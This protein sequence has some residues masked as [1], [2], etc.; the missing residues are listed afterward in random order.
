MSGRRSG[1]PNPAGAHFLADRGVITRLVRAAGI[2]P[3]SLVLDLGAGRGAITLALAAAGA[4]VVAIERDPRLAASLRR[5]VSG[6]SGGAGRLPV[7]VVEADLRTVPLPRREFEVVAN[8]PFSLTTALLRRLLTGPAVRLAGAELIIAWGAA[9]WLTAVPRDA[10]TAWWAAR[11]QLRLASRVPAASFCPPPGTD[12]A[13][14][15][16]RPRP[17]PRSGQGRL[18]SLIRAGYREPGLPAHCLLPGRG[19]RR[20]LARS[21]IDPD[22]AASSL[23]GQQWYQLAALAA[24]RPR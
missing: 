2:G 18:R 13:Q 15:S 3:G 11:Y 24:S 19:G 9:R 1:P 21:G 8:V 7:T 16:V 22:G 17:L 10:E 4:R 14:L 20:A 6:S 12:A 5:R 23:T